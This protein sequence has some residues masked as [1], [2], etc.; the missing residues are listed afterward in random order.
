MAGE[1]IVE[2]VSLGGSLQAVVEQDER[3]AYLYLFDPE[4]AEQAFKS[5]WVRNL[6]PGPETLDLSTMQQ[7]R[8]PLLPRQDTAH[9]QGA[10]PLES[11]DLRLVWLE[12]GHGVALL[13]R[14][15][16][17]PLAIIPP[18]SGHNGMSGYARDCLAAGPLAWPLDPENALLRRTEAA[19]EF[20]ALW[21]QGDSAWESFRAP[22][23]EAIERDLGRTETYY[24][25]DGGTWPPRALLRVPVDG[26][27]ALV[28]V[29]VAIRPQPLV[30][31]Y[32]PDAPEQIWRVELGVCL[33]E[34]Y[35]DAAVE[36]MMR[37]LS[38]QSNFPWARGSWLGEGHT[39]L[40]DAV[41]P[42]TSGPPFE[43]TLLTRWPPQGPQVRLP[44]YRGDPL[45]LL[46]FL[47]ITESERRF[48]MEQGSEALF[49]RLEAAGHG[50]IHKDRAAVV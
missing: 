5:C 49:R 30:E 46:W 8:A 36:G 24:A 43:A 44:S 15:S 20:W 40:C 17:L 6:Q 16:V 50:W 9:P 25:I 31:M 45:S 39:I 12:D 7:G 10:P 2:G 21:E 34:G 18:W 48:A 14:D 3:V 33:A 41:P 42:N 29:G 37:Y 28:T 27:T 47:P 22:M 23:I 11:Q 32:V 26:A 1:V 13:E 35:D 4:A 19:E 38:G